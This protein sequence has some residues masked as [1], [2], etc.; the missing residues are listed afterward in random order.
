MRDTLVDLR[1][2]TLKLDTDVMEAPWAFLIGTFPTRAAAQL[3]QTEALARGV[4]T[5]VV[6]VGTGGRTQYRLYSG[7][8]TGPGDAE[9]MRAILRSAELPDTLVERTGSISS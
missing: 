3:K 5:Y 9:F 1:I 7:T 8:Y 4:P 2:K 6:P